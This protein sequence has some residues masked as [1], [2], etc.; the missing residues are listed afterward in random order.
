M[1][2]SMM[3]TL[4]PEPV[5]P[6]A[7]AAGAPTAVIPHGVISERT[8]TDDATASPG[9]PRPSGTRTSTL[10]SA[11]TRTT[12][13]S[14]IVAKSA[15]AITAR[16]WTLSG[17]W[18]VI[19]CSIASSCPVGIAAAPCRSEAPRPD[20]SPM[21]TRPPACAMALRRV[22]VSTDWAWAAAGTISETTSSQAR[23]RAI[24]TLSA[25]LRCDADSL[26]ASREFRLNGVQN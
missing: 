14:L 15:E 10:E 21:I 9:T 3:P 2:P 5:R 13:V 22:S 23:R 25:A 20:L 18:P 1:P 24:D 11:S 16:P 26:G 7:H 12:S 19:R 6:A 17:Y 8:L 4:T